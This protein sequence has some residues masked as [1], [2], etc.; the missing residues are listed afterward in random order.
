VLLPAGQRSRMNL[1]WMAVLA[2]G[3]IAAAAYVSVDLST[4]HAVSAQPAGQQS[5][6][7][8]NQ[9]QNQAGAPVDG[10]PAYGDPADGDGFGGNADQEFS[11][12][13][14]VQ[15]PK[16][17]VAVPLYDQPSLR[18]S[19]V[20][21]VTNGSTIYINCTTQGDVVT[22]PVTGQRSNFW[23]WDDPDGAYIPAVFVKIGVSQTQ[24]GSC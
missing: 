6:Y 10:A 13:G 7:W 20:T 19:V 24:V 9:A 23:D 5:Y 22:N 16:G 18:S 2:S 3:V 15:A 8:G 21:K 1:R 4:N 14:T 11:I 17:N 12:A